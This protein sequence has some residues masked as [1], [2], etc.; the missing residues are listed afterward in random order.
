SR[1]AGGNTFRASSRTRRSASSSSR[2]CWPSLR[3]IRQEGGHESLKL[4][5]IGESLRRIYASYP[6]QHVRLHK[7][8]ATNRLRRT[9]KLFRHCRAFEAEAE[10]KQYLRTAPSK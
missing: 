1:G 4:Q 3:G 10:P 5:P 2:R 6:E 7:T 9:S 8:A